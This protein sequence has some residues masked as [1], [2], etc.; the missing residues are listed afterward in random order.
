[1]IITANSSHSS[2]TV[3]VAQPHQLTPQG[4][5]L[6]TNMLLVMAQLVRDT[7]KTDMELITPQD[8]VKLGMTSSKVVM[9]ALLIQA[10][11]K[12]HLKPLHHRRHSLGKLGMVQL[13]NSQLLKVV[14]VRQ[15]MVLLRLLRLVTVASHQQ[16]TVPDMEHHHRLESHRLMLRTSSLRVHLGAMVVSLGILNQLRP[17]MDHLRAMGMVKH[18]R[19]M[20]LMEDTHQLLQEEATLL[21]GLL[22]LLLPPVVVVVRRL[23]RVLHQLDRP[24]HLRKVDNGDGKF[25]L[26][27]I[28]GFLALLFFFKDILLFV[29]DVCSSLNFS[30]YI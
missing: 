22:E 4:M 20:G 18:N 30:I 11:R 2:Q 27:Y 9:A 29:V 12:M 15:R 1:M 8:M 21:M 26:L 13:V 16:L 25:Q 10:K 28:T 19:D 23:C 14:P 24:R 6:T 7:S 5:G 17:V 3:V